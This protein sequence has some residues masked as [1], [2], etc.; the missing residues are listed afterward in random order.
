MSFLTVLTL[1]WTASIA[2]LLVV[3]KVVATLGKRDRFFV[4]ID[5]SVPRAQADGT[6]TG[7]TFR[8]SA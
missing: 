2:L 3:W 4:S 1:T 5:P 8:H 7:Q 6:K